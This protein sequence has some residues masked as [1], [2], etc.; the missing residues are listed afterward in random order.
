[1]V[2]YNCRRVA[3]VR[4][5][6]SWI[7]G[8]PTML[9]WKDGA[10][11]ILR[12]PDGR[13]VTPHTQ[14]LDISSQALD[15][16]D[17]FFV[18]CAACLDLK[19]VHNAQTCWISK[20][21]ETRLY[22]EVIRQLNF[23]FGCPAKVPEIRAFM[24]LFDVKTV[25]RIRDTNKILNTSVIPARNLMI[26]HNGEETTEDCRF[27]LHEPYIIRRNKAQYPQGVLSE[28]DAWTN[29]CHLLQ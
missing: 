22:T 27:F 12:H 2:C 24:A 17:V 6:R 26:I 29:L 11:T 20:H 15:V 16:L 3:V 5:R 13:P 23:M 9:G 21:V 28:H 18:S 1:M 10:P 19:G 4:L 25:T 8:K 7:D 14:A